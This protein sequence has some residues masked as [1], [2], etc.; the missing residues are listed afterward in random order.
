LKDVNNSGYYILVCSMGDILRFLQAVEKK[1]AMAIVA[2]WRSCLAGL[3]I[4]DT[5]VVPPCLCALQL[6]GARC[7]HGHRWP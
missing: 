7:V 2:S 6:L 5:M 4:R 3:Q 1:L